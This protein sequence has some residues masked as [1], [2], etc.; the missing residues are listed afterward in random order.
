MERI[1]FGKFFH[2]R[3]EQ[4]NE[5][6]YAAG[7]VG[8]SWYGG[9]EPGDYVF[10]VT[11]KEVIGVW[12]VRE[13]GSKPNRINPDD[14]G[15]VFFD[16]IKT[17]SNPVPVLTFVK[18]PYF[19]LDIN[20]LNKIYRPTF[21]YGFFEIQPSPYFPKQI[22]AIEFVETR[23][24]FVA[25]EGEKIHTKMH[26]VIMVIDNLQKANIVRFDIHSSS[27]YE[28]YIPLRK[29]YE[30]KNP[31][32]ERYSLKELLDYAESD[33][34]RNKEK[35]LR[36]VLKELETRGYFRVDNPIQLYDNIIV[37]RRKTPKSSNENKNIDGQQIEKYDTDD[38]FTVELNEYKKFA[39]LL[40]FNPN[41]ILYGPPGTG[42]TYAT[43]KIIEAFEAS[44]FKAHIPFE[45]IEKEQRVKFVTFHQS[46]SYE[47]FIEGIRPQL[48]QE[49][50]NESESGVRYK[51]EDG[52]LKKLVE[53][54]STQMLKAEIT[55]PGVELLKDTSRVWKVSLGRRNDDSIY[56]RCKQMNKIAIGWLAEYDLKGKT[57]DELYTMLEK[58]LAPG[59]PK[60]TQDA[61]SIHSFINEMSVGDI[62]LIYDS[63]TTIRDIAVVKGEYEYLP[64]ESFPHARDVIWLKNFQEPVDIYEINNRTR[65][66]LK[67]VYELP[68][69][70][71]SDIQK[72]IDADETK[73]ERNTSKTPPK[74]YYLIIDEINR[75][76]I[77]RIF[78]ELI[79][80]IEKDK[81]QTLS[82]T[83]PYSNKPF[84]LPKNLYIIGTMNTADRS[85]AMLDTALRRRFAFVEVEPDYSVFTNPNL[86]VT[87][88]VNNTV[89]LE[90][91]LRTIN[92]KITLQLDRD[93]R[94]GHAYF[95][96]IL[97]LDEL[98]KTWYY[99]ILPLIAEYF[100]NDL[101]AIQNVVGKAFFHPNG[102]M[103]FLS[104]TADDDGISPFER[105]L[106]AIYKGNL[107]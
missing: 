12:R 6:F 74:P 70:S 8:S 77:S 84:T 51:I 95:M 43:K 46:F 80:L 71:M 105:A 57:Y 88:T 66:T 86:N 56:N 10:P 90:A 19:E 30:D 69:I 107:E 103:N 99:K 55:I 21:G 36:S 67:T 92:E 28:E 97:T 2:E 81:R 24:I 87:S 73:L 75:G 11:S 37:G 63:P 96:D 42:K 4:I 40:D 104:M 82:I 52:V 94:I 34:A 49:N 35:Y 5:R 14:P 50:E 72:L 18:S 98:Y 62:V 16:E 101:A 3:P 83:L 26:D 76:N 23:N 45:Q 106:I 61:H 53:S 91:L 33:E 68:R 100:Y 1:F 17:F 59:S 15:V 58:D 60:P 64:G 41:L 13:Y 22:E 7:S 32:G 39:D 25:L 65:L 44:R 27:G 31:V 54:A 89:N 20:L 47:E 29:L 48:Q 79:T 102:S 9:I 78:G 93:H 38:D 85:I